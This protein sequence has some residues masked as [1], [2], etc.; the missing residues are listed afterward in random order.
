VE[1]GR[2]IACRTT[3]FA[4]CSAFPYA[5]AS[6]VIAM[7][8]RTASSTLPIHCFFCVALFPALH[9]KT[10][11]RLLLL[12]PP[13]CLLHMGQRVKVDACQ[14]ITFA[15]SSALVPFTRS[16]AFPTTALPLHRLLRVSALIIGRRI[17]TGQCLT[18]VCRTTTFAASF[19]TESPLSRI[20]LDQS[21][22]NQD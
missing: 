11:W 15:L 20:H 9:L 22:E 2:R 12:L 19:A 3:A 4:A 5:C 8:F 17:K 1:Q 10:A 6:A 13:H 7:D 18:G 14:T 21:S 16:H